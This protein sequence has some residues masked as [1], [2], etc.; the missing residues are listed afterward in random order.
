[1]NFFALLSVLFGPV[2][3]GLFIIYLRNR[4][5]VKTLKNIYN[6]VLWGLLPAFLVVIIHFAFEISRFQITSSIKTTLFYVF[7]SIAFG[8]EFGKFIPV[9]FSL[10]NLKT[11]DS[12]TAGIIY[13]SFVSLTYS[14]IV[15]ILSVVG[16]FGNYLGENQTLFL[17]T[18][19][20]ANLF[21]GIIQGFFIGMHK[22]KRTALVD[23]VTGLGMATGLHM[24]FYFSL[25]ANDHLLYTVTSV[26]LILVGYSL[27]RK[28]ISIPVRT[29]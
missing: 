2:M 7:I 18:Y 12:P 11:F 9:R 14:S 26:G 24:V 29:Y 13:S 23:E 16:F 8:A 3:V 15:V 4:F 19:P 6:A 22:V 1:M 5:K 28:S 17:W 10:Y 21:L 25:L 27:V 20:L